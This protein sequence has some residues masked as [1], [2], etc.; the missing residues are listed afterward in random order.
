MQTKSGSEEERASSILTFLIADIRGYTTFTAERGDEAAARLT[1]RFAELARESVTAHGGNVI[2]FR[3]DEALAVFDSARQAIRTAIELQ[4]RFVDHTVADPS[5]PLAVGIGLDAGE[6][7]PVDDGYRGGALN[8]AARLCSL[9]GPAEILASREVVHL[10]RKMDGITF[11]E[12]GPVQL[13]GLADPVHVLRLRAEA[14]DAAEDMA[15]RR[16]LGAAAARLAPTGLGAMVANPYKGLRAFGE[17]D[18]SDFF[19]REE[20]T[21]LLSGRLAQTRFLA[22]VGPSG[23][24]KSS[25]VRAGLIPALRREAVPG[26]DRWPIAEM[27]PGARPLEELEAAMLRVAANPPSSLMEQLERDDHGLARAVKRVLPADDSELVLVIDQF[28]EVFTLVED[29]GART[30]FLESLE[31]A[32]SEPHS[33]L[34]VVITLR[35][36]FYDRP[37]LYRGFAELLRSR[38]EAVVPL[39]AEEL[40]RVISEP[41]K[42]VDVRLEPGL[43]AQMLSDVA[44]EPGALPLLEY[45]LTE[46]FERRDGNLLTMEAYRAIG[47]VSGALGRTAEELF[48]RLDQP[49]RETARQIFLRLVALGEGAEDT[50][51]PVPRSELSSLEIDQRAMSGVID[52]FGGSRLMSFDRDSRTG[53]PTVEV[54]HEAL[55]TA[56]GRL[57]RWID[58]AR[59]DLRI[60]RRLALAAR[61]WVETDRDPSF[62]A[63]GSR[64]DQ[65]EAWQQSAAISTTPEEREFLEASAQERDRRRQQEEA[66]EQHERALERR[67]VVR[68]RALVAVLGV[69]ALIAGALTAFAFRQRGRAERESRVAVAR[70]LA[71]AAVANMDQDAE[72]SILLALEAVDRARPIGGPPL[73][74][75]EDALH[76]AVDA[77]R[78]VLS[79]PGL[80]GGL[81]WSP[82]GKL[83]VTEGPEE[84]GIIDIR[85]AETGRSVRRFKGH[86]IDVN[87]VVFSADGSRLATTG[88]DN[89]MRVWDPTTGKRLGEFTGNPQSPLVAGPSFSPDGS[90]VAACWIEEGEVRLFDQASGRTIHVIDTVVGPF[91]L[92]FSPDGKHLAV[93]SLDE[94]S[95]VIFDARTFQEERRL[96]GQEFG[97]N[98]VEWSPDGKWIATSANDGTVHLWD[99][100]SGDDR[101]TLFGHTASVGAVDWSPDSTRLVTAGQDGTAKVWEIGDSG[102]SEI[103]SLSSQDTRS[104]VWGVAFSP[105]G[106]RVMTGDLD[107]TA[108]KVWDVSPT[109]DAEWANLP[110]NPDHVNPVAFLSND[111]L[112]ASVPNR[113]IREW[114]VEDGR[115]GRIVVGQGPPEAS[116]DSIGPSPDRKLVAAVIEGVAQV[117]SS[118][119]GNRAFTVG[120]TESGY[121]LDLAWS[122]DGKALA[123]APFDDGVARIVDRSGRQIAALLEETGYGVSALRFSPD[124]KLLATAGQTMGRPN[125]SAQRVKI[126]DW[127]HRKVLRTIRTP[128]DALAFDPVGPRI[129]VVNAGGAT[130]WNFEDGKRVAT[131][132]GGTG[133]FTDIAF[134]P[135]GTL[136][137]A[138]G[139]DSTVRVWDTASGVQR[140]VLRGH[141]AIVT[142]LDFSPDGSR[143]A[144]ASGDGSVRVWALDLND[145]IRIAR[146]ELTR[147]LSDE[148]CRQYLHQSC[149]TS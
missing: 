15:F 56:W 126:W 89:A 112:L 148:E 59:E 85:N 139:V 102:G 18:A 138:S 119:S 1:S 3:G 144:S 109:G 61:E 49:G 48:D 35:A 66:R 69:A 32:V 103:L 24:G 7:V 125:P 63:S 82:D 90:T 78:I 88:D 58:D 52:S 46:L 51:R 118:A 37:L 9:A 55:L 23:S 106:D 140:L 136:I 73:Y 122:P 70:E 34:R 129:A 111:R 135:D 131:L 93:A 92:S 116:V 137:A 22:V 77:S 5:L 91:S 84:S 132:T 41:A 86:D 81:D 96:E 124:G 40:E 29:E 20:L 105:D 74:Q 110:G 115:P 123:T 11:V 54:A 87:F 53:E 95:T 117:W 25:V 39:S 98:D 68:L 50:R 94:S 75:A 133:G 142:D 71:A 30:H 27:M 79:V 97:I 8:L 80:G 57:R 130:I 13:K 6:A 83:F 145:L 128:V 43:A 65:F 47:G 99:A 147:S 28:E 64:L 101:F 107:I 76:Q 19:G 60:E 143:L 149:P 44:N 17:G 10:A 38:V 127:R 4:R 134:S 26:S 62:L 120:S 72:R 42:R 31:V 33:R 36:D 2:E 16:A 114:S 14:E 104:G 67:S 146:N 141:D 121:I 113:S 100:H 12:R 21:N 108:V 45:A